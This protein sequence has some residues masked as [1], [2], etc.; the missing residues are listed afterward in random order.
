MKR[1]SFALQV[2]QKIIFMMIFFVSALTFAETNNSNYSLGA[3]LGSPTAITGRYDF[4]SQNAVDVGLS[5][6]YDYGV[7][8]YSD[9][10]W[11]FPGRFGRRTKFLSEVIPYI[12][13]GAG[14]Y[15]WNNQYRYS[16]RP[17]GW[18][19]N[20][21]N[22]FGLYGR[23]P[24]G[25]E[26]IPKNIPIGVFAEIAPGLALLPGLWLTADIGIGIRYRF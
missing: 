23:V 4:S 13:A 17:Y 19:S 26:W 21:T 11:K 25:A 24:F 20:D 15:S 5:F 7:L 18:K 1:Q 9:Y 10:L 16:D 8:I 22:G 6:F 12:G 3:I 14:L 2:F